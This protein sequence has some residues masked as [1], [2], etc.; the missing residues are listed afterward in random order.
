[1]AA[2]T[3]CCVPLKSP[4]TLKAPPQAGLSLRHSFPAFKSHSII[5]CFS[6]MAYRSGR[7]IDTDTLRVFLVLRV[8]SD[9]QERKQGRSERLE[10]ARLKSSSEAG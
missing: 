9:D 3:C 5:T 7:M 1:M 8:L 10:A 4:N 6:P 2:S